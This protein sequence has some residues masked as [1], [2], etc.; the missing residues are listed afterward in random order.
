MRHFVLTCGLVLGLGLSTAAGEAAAQGI[1]YPQP[2]PNPY[3]RPVVSPYL[4]L[5]RGGNP[6]INYF[7]LTKPQLDFNKQV[8][9][10]QQQGALP[11]Q[12]GMY[13]FGF[14]M[15]EYAYAPNPAAISGH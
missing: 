2:T 4:N 11:L 5:A 10:Q 7:G 8:Q 1:Y 9:L 14:Q 3:A 12:L 15:D 13:Q 6:A